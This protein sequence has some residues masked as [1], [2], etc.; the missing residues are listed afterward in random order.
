M[1]AASATSLAACGQLSGCGA[2][3]KRR[4][5]RYSAARPREGRPSGGATRTRRHDAL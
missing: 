1:V 2:D 5:R 3:R 4:E